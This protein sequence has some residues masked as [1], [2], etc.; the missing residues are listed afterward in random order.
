MGNLIYPK[1]TKHEKRMEIVKEPIWPE[2][3][4]AKEAA[5][6]GSKGASYI[7]EHSDN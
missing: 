4:V 2:H 7:A 3:D 1:E 6:I 5:N